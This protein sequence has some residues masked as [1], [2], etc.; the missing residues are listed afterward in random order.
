MD[1]SFDKK[2]S[3][4]GLSFLQ[5]EELHHRLFFGN[6]WRGKCLNRQVLWSEREPRN[7]KKFP[8]WVI[9]NAPQKVWTLGN[10][11]FASQKNP[12]FPRE[13]KRPDL[14]HFEEEIPV[15]QHLDKVWCLDQLLKYFHGKTTRKSR[16][17]NSHPLKIAWQQSALVFLCERCLY[18]LQ[19]QNRSRR[20]QHLWS[21]S[22]EKPNQNLPSFAQSD[23]KAKNLIKGCL[24]ALHQPKWNKHSTNQRET[25]HSSSNEKKRD[26]SN[27]RQGFVI[28]KSRQ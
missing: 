21:A 5:P 3:R 12:R 26:E 4:F 15:L 11:A 28:G 2:Y 8:Q 17:K 27:Q 6:S 1:E 10:S 25:E 19:L 22:R 14:S 13:I 7:F 16:Q 9:W 18:Q 20:V 23:Q 24:R